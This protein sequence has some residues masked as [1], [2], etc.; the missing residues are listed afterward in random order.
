[1][2]GDMTAFRVDLGFGGGEGAHVFFGIGPLFS[3]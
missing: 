3:R 1:M 2:T